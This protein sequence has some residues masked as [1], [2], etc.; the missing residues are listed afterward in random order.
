MSTDTLGPGDFAG[1]YFGAEVECV[2]NRERVAEAIAQVVGGE[3]RYDCGNYTWRDDEGRTWKCGSDS[4]ISVRQGDAGFDEDEDCR[5]EWRCEINFPPFCYAERMMVERVLQH[6]AREAIVNRSCGLHLHVSGDALGTPL[7]LANLARLV[8]SREEHLMRALNVQ[9]RRK[10]DY[11]KPMDESFR[12]ALARQTP[13]TMMRLAVAWYGSERECADYRGNRW[14][15]SR[16]HA[17]NLN[18]YFHRETVE[19]RFFEATLDSNRF[20]ANVQLVAALARKAAVSDRA[21][22]MTQRALTPECEKYDVRRFLVFLGMNGKEFAKARSFFTD[23]L[24]GTGNG[25][26]RA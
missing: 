24:C 3:P 20:W 23:H 22:P 2:G 19:F 14:H 4:S 26:V 17:L 18:S 9:E 5:D 7:A 13:E 6:V 8:G 15:D 12:S 10:R 1:L 11:A 16:Y 25:L 21:L